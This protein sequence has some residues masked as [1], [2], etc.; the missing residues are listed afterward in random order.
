[1]NEDLKPLYLFLSRVKGRVTTVVYI[2][3]SQS[4]AQSDA[5]DKVDG[6]C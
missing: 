2:D 4:C 1:M 5:Q 6:F 3:T